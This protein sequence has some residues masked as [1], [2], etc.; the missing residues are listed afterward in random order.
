M[1][2]SGTFQDGRTLHLRPLGLGDYLLWAECKADWPRDRKGYYTLSRAIADTDRNVRDNANV[3]VPLGPD[4]NWIQTL[5][6]YTDDVPQGIGVHRA[7]AMG[8]AVHVLQ[9]AIHPA[10]RGA[11]WFSLMNQLLSR[12]AFEVIGADVVTFEIVESATGAKTYVANRSMYGSLG[13]RLGETGKTLEAGRQ[14]AADYEQWAKES[15]ERVPSVIITAQ[16]ARVPS[17]PE[18]SLGGADLAEP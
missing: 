17:V 10:H 16:D 18:V 4:T 12:Y 1:I 3:V 9:Q 2:I 11:G 14:R 8:T 15:P 7:R 6:A 5:V 13:E